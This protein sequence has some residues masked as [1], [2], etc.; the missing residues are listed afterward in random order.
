M[1][2]YIIIGLIGVVLAVLALAYLL[3]KL[4][5]F[6]WVARIFKKSPRSIWFGFALLLAGVILI[7]YSRYPHPL[8]FAVPP[9]MQTH[10]PGGDKPSLPIFNAIK[11]LFNSNKFEK[12]ADIGR[13][14]NDV[15]APID[16]SF[17]TLVKFNLT[18]KEVIGE[19]SNGIYYN[20]W[21][22]NGTTPGPML[23][24]K[25][26]DDVEITLT[27]DKTSLHHHNIDLHAVNGPGGGAALTDVAPGQS[28]TFRFKATNPGLYE[29][30]CAMMNVSVHNAHGQYGAILVEPREGLEKV[31]KEFY[32]MQGELYTQGGLGEKGLTVFDADKMLS[33]QPTYITFNG[34]I[35]N[36]PRMK[37]T[38]GQK[39][40]I[41]VANGGVNLISSFHIIGEVFDKVYP[42]GAMG[43]DSSILKNVQTTAVLPGGAAVV[44][45][46]TEVPGKYLLVDHALARM[47]RGAWAQY[48]VE[49][50]SRDDLFMQ[51]IPSSD[52]DMPS[53]Q[54]HGM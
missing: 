17:N 31:D 33:S 8:D 39:I 30:H 7:F 44:E 1:Y 3:I 32:V 15:P 23:R 36:G 42:E 12:V 19:V 40:R 21:T 29:Y 48:I 13:D 43:K 52:T 20:Y 50:P 46:K 27:N 51:M 2:L 41:Y 9:M 24:V 25:E 4:R 16:R 11:F 6:K 35:E 5:F 14:P 26:G 34:K 37:S 22:Y 10:N 38:A 47:N 49:G 28:K 18:A 45:F 53:M 54:E